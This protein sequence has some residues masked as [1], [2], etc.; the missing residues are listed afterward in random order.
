MFDPILLEVGKLQKSVPYLGEIM[1]GPN[2]REKLVSRGLQATYQE[3]DYPAY[4]RRR[5]I[6][7]HCL[8]FT[9]TRFVQAAA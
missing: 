7:G 8:T 3:S 2:R 5:D 1:P 9:I 6:G 4:S